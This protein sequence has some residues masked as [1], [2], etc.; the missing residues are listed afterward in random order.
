MTMNKGET[1]G[2]RILVVDDEPAVRLFLKASL[3]Q[4]GYEVVEVASGEEALICIQEEPIDVVLL[5]LKLGGLDGLEVMAKMEEH[6]LAPVVIILT[7]YASLDSAIEAMRKGGRDYLVKPCSTEKLLDS[8]QEGVRR[9]LRAL[10][11]QEMLCLIETTAHKLCA[12]SRTEKTQPQQ[13]TPVLL[14]G[15]G[16]LMDCR[17]GTVT[18]MGQP[19]HLTPTEF[20]LLTILMER[21]DELVSYREL[22]RGLYGKGERAKNVRHTLTTHLWR[23]RQKLG[24]GP[25]GVAYLVNVRGRGYRF[26]GKSESEE[27]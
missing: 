1:K 3:E 21:A 13:V 26:I 4:A 2:A 7:A 16:L 10:R 8:V 5:D 24:C 19:L 18:R 17:K 9:R 23:L 27:K 11:R 15:R 14:E 20:R 6:P 12:F 22:T 25:D